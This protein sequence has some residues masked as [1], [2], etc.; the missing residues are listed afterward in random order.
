MKILVIGDSCKDIYKYGICDRLDQEAPVPIFKEEKEVTYE[1]MSL[2]VAN[3]VASFGINCDLITNSKS[4]K[5]IRFVDIRSNQ[6]VMRVDEN[7]G[8]PNIRKL[9]E[10]KLNKYD[11][12]IVSDYNKGFLTE[13]QMNYIAS[14][15]KLSFLQT[16]KVL[17]KWCENFSYIKI[18]NYEFQNTS[19]FTPKKYLE[20]LN[21]IITKGEKGAV[22]K[23][24]N[25]QIKKPVTIRSLAGAGDTFLA[26]LV[27]SY[28][29][30]KNIEKSI[31][32]AQ[33]Q[34]KKAV[35]ELGISVVG[36]KKNNK[37]RIIKI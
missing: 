11:A 8:I 7:D 3:N 6:L 14:N 22:F 24:K 29:Q 26:G 23:N 17:E 25:F 27:S 4:I 13:G 10:I 30:N 31:N 5:K 33:S 20:Q 21:L 18:N 15:S 9:K 36:E 32:F 16:N 35:S 19:Q 1:G 2:N 12:V 34:S 37:P 28:V